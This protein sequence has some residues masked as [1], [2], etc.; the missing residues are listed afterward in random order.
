MKSVVNEKYVKQTYEALSDNN[1]NLENI[2]IQIS[3]LPIREQN[4]YLRLI[5]N[6]IENVANNRKIKQPPVG[7]SQAIELCNRLMI[8]V[9][10]Y[11]EEQDKG[12]M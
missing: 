2:A 12:A 1:I 5:I 6:Y 11:Y 8:V 10:E 3:Q 4:K 9:N 7:L